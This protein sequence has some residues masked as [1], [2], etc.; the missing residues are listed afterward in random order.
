MESKACSSA[1]P[2]ASRHGTER[3]RIAA[4]A[5][6]RCR[7]WRRSSRKERRSPIG[8]GGQAFSLDTQKMRL[9]DF[10]ASCEPA[11]LTETRRPR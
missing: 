3:A 6:Q 11:E 1:S 9:L 5:P 2:R 10:F 8:R 4:S 7:A